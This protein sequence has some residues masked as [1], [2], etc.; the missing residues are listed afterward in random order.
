MKTSVSEVKN[1]LKKRN[2]EM[3]VS[4]NALKKQTVEMDALKAK[5]VELEKVC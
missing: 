5:I 3:A 1:A 4:E 2:E